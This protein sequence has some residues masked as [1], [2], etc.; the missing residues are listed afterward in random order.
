MSNFTPFPKRLTLFGCFG[1]L[2]PTG[3]GGAGAPP[4]GLCLGVASSASLTSSGIS[5]I[6]GRSELDS[7]FT[8]NAPT[9][10]PFPVRL[11]RAGAPPP[12]SGDASS[13]RGSHQGSPLFHAPL[14]EELDVGIGG[15]CNPNSSARSVP[16]GSASSALRSSSVGLPNKISSSIVLS[17][18]SK[19]G[20]SR[21][22]SSAGSSVV[23]SS[24]GISSGLS[25]SLM[26]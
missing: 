11:G 4:S 8:R 13:E 14:L 15:S 20:S 18:S 3:F 24:G 12:G 16:S 26:L 19:G 2:T 17:S 22:S 5:G 9:A 23:S 7:N 1:G 21:S 6:V 25:T 10:F